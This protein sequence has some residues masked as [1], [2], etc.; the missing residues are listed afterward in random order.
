MLRVQNLKNAFQGYRNA[1]GHYIFAQEI[2][3]K[4]GPFGLPDD[5]M[6]DIQEDYKR[7]IVTLGDAIRASRA[8]DPIVPGAREAYTQVKQFGS[9]PE[10]PVI[11]ESA[12]WPVIRNTLG[13]VFDAPVTATLATMRQ[14]NLPG[15]YES[16]EDWLSNWAK[17]YQAHVLSPT[18]RL[19]PGEQWR[20]Y[21][22]T[23][24]EKKDIEVSRVKEYQGTP[25]AA[26]PF[27]LGLSAFR[28]LAEER[29]ANALSGTK[30][31]T[32][33]P[34]ES[35]QKMSSVNVA[36]VD[37]PEDLGAVAADVAPLVTSGTGR[38]FSVPNAFVR[39]LTGRG[40]GRHA[41]DAVTLGAMKTDAAMGKDWA[42]RFI[43]LI[44]P[45]GAL[46]RAHLN[47]SIKMDSQAL[48]DDWV[49]A[50]VE[51]NAI[52]QKIANQ[53]ANTMRGM[54]VEDRRLALNVAEGSVPMS[55]APPHI[56]EAAKMMREW[57]ETVGRAHAQSLGYSP[58]NGRNNVVMNPE[59]LA[60]TTVPENRL[61]YVRHTWSPGWEAEQ[62]AKNLGFDPNFALEN[63]AP[64]RG[65]NPPFVATVPEHRDWV[66]QLNKKLGLTPGQNPLAPV[67]LG[68]GA[69]KAKLEVA[70]RKWAQEM[71]IP[72]VPLEDTV[73]DVN[74]FTLRWFGQE[75]FNPDPAAQALYR[76]RQ[77]NQTPFANLLR[78]WMGK[79]G[80]PRAYP[81]EP[82]VVDPSNMGT[83]VP[84]MRTTVSTPAG[85]SAAN[86]VQ[87]PL[88]KR[89]TEKSDWGNL[90]DDLGGGTM[91]LP[92]EIATHVERF[93]R[94][95]SLISPLDAARKG[96]QNWKAAVTALQ[97]PYHFRNVIN[98]TGTR[99]AEQGL[100]AFHPAID[101]ALEALANNVPTF[102][103]GGKTYKTAEVKKYLQG[104]GTIDPDEIAITNANVRGDVVGMSPYE[105]VQSDA[106]RYTPTTRTNKTWN[107]D[108]ETT[109]NRGYSNPAEDSVIRKA[110]RNFIFPRRWETTRR[111]SQLG[112]ELEQGDRL[113]FVFGEMARGKSLEE[114]A[115]SADFHLFNRYRH[116]EWAQP[117]TKAGQIGSTII[118]FG[119]WQSANARRYAVNMTE[120]PRSIWG[121]GVMPENVSAELNLDTDKDR[122]QFLSGRYRGQLASGGPAIALGN[123]A[124]GKP[125]L[126]PNAAAAMA[127]PIDAV[128]FFTSP[129]SW[130]TGGPANFF[131]GPVMRRT[132]PLLSN[133][134]MSL[135][136]WDPQRQQKIWEPLQDPSGGVKAVLNQ[137]Q[138]AGRQSTLAHEGLWALNDAA[139]GAL[140]KMGIMP[141]EERNFLPV[142]QTQRSEKGDVMQRKSAARMFDLIRSP[143]APFGGFAESQSEIDPGLFFGMS[144]LGMTPQ[145]MDW[146]K[147]LSQDISAEENY[148]RLLGLQTNKLKKQVW[149]DIDLFQR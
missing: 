53:Y 103:I 27:W 73:K 107:L 135:F 6:Q 108:W 123:S 139:N 128:S 115:R 78:E 26:A 147:M 94:N 113:R 60:D 110:S 66:Y 29:K 7:S 36:G 138:Q 24:P 69:H 64:S 132:N 134:T 149:K 146:N 98:N 85:V 77:G 21:S 116:P 75:A 67:T 35:K 50:Q 28:G 97:P 140:S 30:P 40:M 55:Q 18:T 52:P 42:T 121:L 129:S 57:D 130:A 9:R 148:R 68:G 62:K 95:Q 136:N 105:Q 8:E 39:G 16:G 96:T 89:L 51:A 133:I 84:D 145:V 20:M 19:T 45:G 124:T 2:M 48:F 49:R 100:Y 59:N 10:I 86:P 112:T 4:G 11:G 90:L 71:G 54:S 122:R 61:H 87:H 143:F 32:V 120:N 81:H 5:Q 111:M 46:A 117:N 127:E 93:S 118:P 3:E 56:Q 114:A 137:V 63:A 41:W 65:P 70:R 91:V 141:N 31:V 125:I 72:T 14:Q 76:I 38:V 58:W 25:A 101:D 126:A 34:T 33:E 15:V 37:V 22:R 92:E 109:R 74:D 1:L 119:G 47:P 12:P 17:N 102:R 106:L 83:V 44:T 80:K 99:V 144:T 23:H 142:L 82:N 131:S 88:W 79:Y 13:A 43:D 104:H